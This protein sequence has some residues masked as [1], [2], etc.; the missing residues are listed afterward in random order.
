MKISARN[1]IAGTIT[2]IHKGATTA[3]VEIDVGGTVITAAITNEA[4]DQLRLAAGQKAY[5][6]IKASDVMVGVADAG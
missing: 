3:H 2:A 6:V 4:V 1:Q 5:A